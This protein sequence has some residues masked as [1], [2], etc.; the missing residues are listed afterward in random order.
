MEIE[1]PFVPMPMPDP[2]WTERVSVLVAA[3]VAHGEPVPWTH[4][5]DALWLDD[6][7]D[8]G[9]ASVLGEALAWEGLGVVVSVRGMRPHYVVVLD[10]HSASALLKLA[11]PILER[12]RGPLP[13]GS[14]AVL[15]LRDSEASGLRLEMVDL[16]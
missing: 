16:A 1:D 5:D 4:G 6:L 10:G 11:V 15:T 7:E 13:A 2:P 12:V 14:R 8:R 9:L 3:H